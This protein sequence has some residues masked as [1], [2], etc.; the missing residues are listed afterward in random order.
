[1]DAADVLKYL[2]KFLTFFFFF[3]PNQADLRQERTILLLEASPREK[4]NTH[5]VI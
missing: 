4:I 1:M 5:S 3:L 2:Y